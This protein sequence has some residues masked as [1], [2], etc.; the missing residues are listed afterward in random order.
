MKKKCY[1]KVFELIK[2]IIF[3]IKK[4]A[5]FAGMKLPIS[6][7]ICVFRSA[8]KNVKLNIWRKYQFC[9]DFAIFHMIQ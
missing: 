6:V 9:L 7:K 8:L 5:L 2:M 4:G 1:D 3:S